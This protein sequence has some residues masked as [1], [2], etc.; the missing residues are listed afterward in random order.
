M[1]LLHYLLLHSLSS[2]PLLTSSLHS[3]LSSLLFCSFHCY[4]LPFSLH[5]LSSLLLSSLSSFLLSSFLI[6]SLT[7]ANFSFLL[8]LPLLFTSLFSLV[9][10]YL[11]FVSYFSPF[12]HLFLFYSPFLSTLLFLLHFITFYSIELYPSYFC[13]LQYSPVG[14]RTNYLRTV[15]NRA[16]YEYNLH[17]YIIVWELL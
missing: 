1:T 15:N 13:L 10:P 12:L 6:T 14:D 5:T 9:F 11:A 4:P 17:M 2:S 8:F 7:S 3:P 16:P